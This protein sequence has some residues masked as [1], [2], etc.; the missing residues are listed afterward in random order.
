MISKLDDMWNGYHGIAPTLVEHW[1]TTKYPTLEINTVMPEGGCVVD[2]TFCPQRVLQGSQYAGERVLSLDNFKMV[3]DKLPKEIRIT[4]SGF[5]EPWLNKNCTDMLVYA[6]EQ[7]HEVAAFTTGVGMKPEDVYRLLDVEFQA[8]TPNGGLVLHLPDKERIAK[9][10]M[11]SNFIK[12]MEAFKEIQHKLNGFTIM[13]MGKVHPDIEHVYTDEDAYVPVMWGRAGNLNK[14][15]ILKPELAELDYLTTGVSETPMT[16]NCVEDLYH[17]VLLPNGEV[18]LCCEDYNLQHIIGNLFEE[19]YNEIVPKPNTCFDLCNGCENQKFPS[20]DLPT[21]VRGPS[22]SKRKELDWGVLIEN[23]WFIDTLQREIFDDEVYTKYFGVEEGDVVLDVGASVGPF[24]Y[25]ILDNKPS[26][27]YCLEPHKKLFKTLESNLQITGGDTRIHLINS[28]LASEDGM[29]EF[30]G[31][32]NDANPTK[33]MNEHTD[34][35][36][37]ITFKTLRHKHNIKQIDFLKTDCE[38]GEY[39]I[40]TADN[41][42]WIKKNVRKISGEFHLHDEEHQEKFR[43]FRDLYLAEFPLHYVEAANYVDIVHDLWTDW[44]IEYYD[45][46]NLYI[47]NS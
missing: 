38:G 24:A 10:P 7:G 6:Y 5:T 45:M 21:T 47:D 41:L 42:K 9:H 13:S 40:F 18:S 19:E 35:A 37:G 15:V 8:N 44:F 43:A 12:V 14:E 23:D 11:N 39:D 26:T 22:A 27:I 32:Y 33:E 1:R 25:S 34:F 17:N 46:V 30:G 20:P 36:D 28:G 2:C 4:F 31:L 29:V 3:I 16:C